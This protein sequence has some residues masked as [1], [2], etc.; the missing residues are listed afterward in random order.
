MNRSE[1][2][3]AVYRYHWERKKANVKPLNKNPPKPNVFA[4]PR[5]KV[6]WDSELPNTVMTEITELPADP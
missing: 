6:P 2:H 4:F 5:I 3:E 1:V